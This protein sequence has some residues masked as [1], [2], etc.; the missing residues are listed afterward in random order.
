[1]D[2]AQYDA[3]LRKL[4]LQNIERNS[5]GL[6]EKTFKEE[7]GIEPS[8][9]NPPNGL[10]SKPISGALSDYLQLQRFNKNFSDSL[11]GEATQQQQQEKAQRKIDA[12]VVNP[13]LFQETDDNTQQQL[14]ADAQAKKFK[15]LKSIIQQK[16]KSTTTDWGD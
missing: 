9:P 6:P 3:M 2:N 4:Q 10:I 11:A 15:K 1:M 7:Y 13:A 14:D 16:A 5:K 8:V 12:T